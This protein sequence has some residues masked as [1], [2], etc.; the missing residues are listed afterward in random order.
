MVVRS[1]ARALLAAPF[2]H[3]GVDAVRH[4]EEHV[5]TARPALDLV[6]KVAQRPPLTPTETVRVVRAHG[7]LTVAAGL[8][9]ASG[10][11]P[12]TS[13]LALTLLT[14]PL[15]VARQPFTR[16][17]EGAA[18]PGG[19]RRAPLQPFLQTLAL[20]GATTL[21]T[22]DTQGRPSLAWRVRHAR[23]QRRAGHED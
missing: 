8:V 5:A 19:R 1:L 2:V 22:A 21:E 13:A 15:A 14:L 3:D 16:H 23:E 9:L 7:A 12:R 18:Q 20:V 10:R 4:P 17:P 11:A 6:T